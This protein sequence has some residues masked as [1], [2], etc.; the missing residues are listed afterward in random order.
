MS[1]DKRLGLLKK[2]FPHLTEKEL[3][4][5]LREMEGGTRGHQ[6]PVG[7]GKATLGRIA[8]DQPQGKCGRLRGIVKEG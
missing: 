5:A 7:R 2:L 3:R 4:D 6:R 8:P 1:D